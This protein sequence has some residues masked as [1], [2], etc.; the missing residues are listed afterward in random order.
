MFRLCVRSIR[1]PTRAVLVGAALF[2]F[3][4][5]RHDEI[6]AEAAESRNAVAHSADASLPS[7]IA[8]DLTSESQLALSGSRTKHTRVTRVTGS[9]GRSRTSYLV[10]DPSRFTGSTNAARLMRIDVDENGDATALRADG[11]RRALPIDA[12]DF[13]DRISALPALPGAVRSAVNNTLAQLAKPRPAERKMSGRGIDATLSTPSSRSATLQALGKNAAV[14][15]R[16]QADADHYV[17][18]RGAREVDVS[19]DPTNQLV[20]GA[21]FSE[22]GKQVAELRLGWTAVG[23]GLF[24]R[25]SAELTRRASDTT[26]ATRTRITLSNITIDGKEVRP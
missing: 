19:V 25:H 15:R 24:I 26:G 20:V 6:A 12:R 14:V 3:T 7:S 8:F 11:S 16:G 2:G 9:D 21:T 22:H 4:G 17:T 13:V 23:A 10:D 5:C 1:G 18:T